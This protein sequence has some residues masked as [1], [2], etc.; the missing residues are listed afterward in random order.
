MKHRKSIASLFAVAATYCSLSLLILR[1]AV[2][3]VEH[4]EAQVVHQVVSL[5]DAAAAFEAI[6]PVLRHPRCMNCH[7]RGDF[8]RQGDD[9]H[10]HT[11]QIRR[12]D[13]QGINSVRCSTCHQD[14]NLAGLHMP[15]GAPGW[16]LPSPAMPMIWEGLTDHQL[17]E[18]FKDPQQN[19][20]RTPEQIVEH[21]HTPLV[22]WGWAPGDGRV[23]VPMDQKEF[24]ARV[25]EWAAKGAACPVGASAGMAPGRS[26]VHSGSLYAANR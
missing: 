20:H 12:G 17:C 6:V 10:R 16:N 4:A 25:Q 21:M 18:L 23:P 3:R 15:P 19:G 7:S 9:S 8:P 13:G 26:V 5:D 22:L 2:P 24:F 14:H 1:L 11:M